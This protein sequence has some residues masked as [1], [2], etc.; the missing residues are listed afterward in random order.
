MMK[1]FVEA[2]IV[3]SWISDE[4]ELLNYRI[5]G[6]QEFKYNSNRQGVT[7]F[8]E[9][10]VNF[11]YKSL[12]KEYNDSTVNTKSFIRKVFFYSLIIVLTVLIVEF[13]VL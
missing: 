3:K 6:Y 12:M 9:F 11:E 1:N 7:F 13:L 4:K 5:S 10:Y 8:K 2:K